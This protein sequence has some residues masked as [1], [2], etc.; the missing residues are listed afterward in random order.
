MWTDCVCYFSEWVLQAG[1]A[2]LSD[3]ISAIFS[4]EALQCRTCMSSDCIVIRFGMRLAEDV[5]VKTIA[6]VCQG[7][8]GMDCGGIGLEAESFG[9]D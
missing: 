7:G 3:F 1:F 4:A 9:W 6:A 2:P 8:K 5:A